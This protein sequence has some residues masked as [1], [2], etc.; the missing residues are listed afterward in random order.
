MDC[1]EKRVDMRELTP[2]DM[3]NMARMS[4]LVF[5]LNHTDPTSPAYGE[6]LK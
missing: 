1:E 3:E 4:K 2:S 6:K 5:E